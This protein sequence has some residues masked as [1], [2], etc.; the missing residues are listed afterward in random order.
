MRGRNLE[1]KRRGPAFGTVQ[2]D[3][4]DQRRFVNFHLAPEKLDAGEYVNRALGRLGR[5]VNLVVEHHRLIGGE[6]VRN[7]RNQFRPVADQGI[8]RL[9]LGRGDALAGQHHGTHLERSLAQV[10]N[11]KVGFKRTQFAILIFAHHELQMILARRKQKSGVVL[12]VLAPSDRAVLDGQL[13]GLT[14]VAHRELGRLVANQAKH[15]ERGLIAGS[16]RDR[17]SRHN[18]RQQHKEPVRFGAKILGRKIHR[19]VGIRQIGIQLCFHRPVAIVPGKVPE[20]ARAVVAAAVVEF[21]SGPVHLDDD[22]AVV[23]IHRGVRG[24]V[25]ENVIALHVRLHLGERFAEIVAVEERLAAGVGGERD[26]RLL[27]L[28]IRIVSRGNRVAVISGL[29]VQARQLRAAAG[30]NRFQSARVHRINR[31]IGFDGDVDG[32]AQLRLVFVAGIA[33]H[34]AAEVEHGFFLVDVPERPGQRGDCL[35]TAVGVEDVVLGVVFGVG[36]S[37]VG[38]A[39]G[40]AGRPLFHPLALDALH[41][42]HRLPKQVMIGGEVLVHLHRAAEAHDGD[43]IRRRHLLVDEVQSALAGAIQLV[44][45]HVGQIEEQHDQ[46]AVA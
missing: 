33:I 42:A 26:Q 46:A 34:A 15:V 14:D 43:Q 6:D 44:G 4:F 10:R 39:F 41:A 28:E 29:A 27:R 45:L 21:H 20:I 30:D 2:L 19:Q 11:R 22:L 38:L 7:I 13:D 3:A 8:L 23:P 32:G 16:G 12:R 18:R 25:A 1:G 9:L 40:R 36:L 37:L 24:A 31:N 17:R 5:I 35:Q